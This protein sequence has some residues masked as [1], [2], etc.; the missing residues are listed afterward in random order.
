MGTEYTSRKEIVEDLKFCKTLADRLVKYA[1]STYRDNCYDRHHTVIQDD[2][3]R[4][5][6]E[7]TNVS[8]KL[9]WNYRL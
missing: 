3:R 7:L 1:E 9:D 8:H 2:I 4:L 6:R 5:R